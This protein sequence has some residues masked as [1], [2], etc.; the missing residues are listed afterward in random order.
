[1]T[2]DELLFAD[3][4]LESLRNNRNDK[5]AADP[6]R[7]AKKFKKQPPSVENPAFVELKEAIENEITKRN[8]SHG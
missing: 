1:M 2:D 4:S 8:L 5:L 7:T 6:V 3:L